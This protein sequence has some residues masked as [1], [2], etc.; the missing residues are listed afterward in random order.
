MSRFPTGQPKSNGQRLE[1][2]TRTQ[3]KMWQS[4]PE[5]G[6][7]GSSLLFSCPVPMPPLRP[8]RHITSLFAFPPFHFRNPKTEMW[9]SSV[10]PTLFLTHHSLLAITG[11]L[12]SD[13]VFSPHSSFPQRPSAAIDSFVKELQC[14]GARVEF[15]TSVRGEPAVSGGRQIINC[16]SL[17]GDDLS[18]LYSG[19]PRTKQ[20]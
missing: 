13:T 11:T 19:F 8:L 1:I 4:C 12:R 3:C 2:K 9:V 10:T 17:A 20:P 15:G 16:L 18:V 5:P 7:P 14:E 6:Q